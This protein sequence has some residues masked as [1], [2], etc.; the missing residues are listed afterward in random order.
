MTSTCGTATWRSDRQGAGGTGGETEEAPV[1]V[2]VPATDP[3]AGPSLGDVRRWLASMLASSRPRVGIHTAT[4]AEP[5]VSPAWTDSSTL[6]AA[7]ARRDAGGEPGAE[8]VSG[9]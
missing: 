2:W 3:L 4:G 6:A 1:A 9:A 5:A 7:Q 8:P